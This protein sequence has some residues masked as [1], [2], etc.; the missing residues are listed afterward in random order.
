[1]PDNTKYCEHCLTVQTLIRN[2]YANA[3]NIIYLAIE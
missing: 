2:K 3:K 1:M